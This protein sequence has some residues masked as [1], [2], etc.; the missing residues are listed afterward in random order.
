MALSIQSGLI[1]TRKCLR[2]QLRRKAKRRT[3]QIVP[4]EIDIQADAYI[5]EYYITDGRQK[6]RCTNVSAILKR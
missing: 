4:V 6:S 1:S 2:K 3:K 5:P